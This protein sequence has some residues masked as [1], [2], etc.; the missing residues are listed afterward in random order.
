MP[1]HSFRDPADFTKGGRW[2][3]DGGERLCGWTWNDETK[4]LRV[5]CGRIKKRLN[6]SKILPSPTPEQL[7]RQLP[8]FAFAVARRIT[9][10]S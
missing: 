3:D 4:M 5:D 7:K 9:E 8:A 6:V 10:G 2:L 1:T